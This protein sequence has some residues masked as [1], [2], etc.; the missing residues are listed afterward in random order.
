MGYTFNGMR[1]TPLA[2]ESTVTQK[3]MKT[4]STYSLLVRSEEK[5]LSIF[6]NVIYALIVLCAAF[7]MWQFVHHPVTIPAHRSAA[8]ITTAAEVRS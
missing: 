7:S 1:G 6:E 5:Q 4:E 8:A 2:I 3:N